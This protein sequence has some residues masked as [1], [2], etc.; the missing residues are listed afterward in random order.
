MNCRRE[1]TGTICW[2]ERALDIVSTLCTVSVHIANVLV[3]TVHAMQQC[4]HCA[5]SLHTDH[6]IATPMHTLC[7]CD[8]LILLRDSSLFRQ[9]C[10]IPQILAQTALFYTSDLSSNTAR[11]R[12]IMT[13]RRAVNIDGESFR[14]PFN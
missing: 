11:Q 8:S 5:H 2:R 1:S 10:S 14:Q 9:H 12:H 3:H 6:T 13:A 4:T 7:S